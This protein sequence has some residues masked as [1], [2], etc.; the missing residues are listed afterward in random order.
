MRT[1][2]RDQGGTITFAGNAVDGPTASGVAQ[3]GAIPFT[4]VRNATGNYTVRFDPRIVPLS[5]NGNA[6]NNFQF[7]AGGVLG[8]GVLV[9]TLIDANGLAGNASFAFTCT[10]LDKRT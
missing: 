4:A 8:A 1:S 5:A 6:T 9:F 10:A 3:P 2:Q 7:A